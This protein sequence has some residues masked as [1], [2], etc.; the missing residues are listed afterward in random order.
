LNSSKIAGKSG[1]IT[2]FHPDGEGKAGEVDV[3]RKVDAGAGVG[4]G[5]AAND[6][7]ESLSFCKSIC[8]CVSVGVVYV[9]VVE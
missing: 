6:A 5:L 7:V 9:S 8:S 2:E 3:I 1:T 4:G